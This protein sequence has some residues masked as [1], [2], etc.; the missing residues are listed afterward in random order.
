MKAKTLP[1]LYT[2]FSLQL[3]YGAHSKQSDLWTFLRSSIT[4]LWLQ[5]E[6]QNKKTIL[7]CAHFIYISFPSIQSS[8]LT[9]RLSCHP[10]SWICMHAFVYVHCCWLNSI[11]VISVQLNKNVKF[12]VFCQDVC[13][14]VC[15]FINGKMENK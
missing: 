3:S 11:I 1:V 13:M 9:N 8:K 10:M 15:A 2:L 12:I 4:T 6:K 5:V 7:I 14:C